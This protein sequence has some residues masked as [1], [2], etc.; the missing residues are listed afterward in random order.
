MSNHDDRYLAELREN[1]PQR[2][3]LSI[4]FGGFKGRK[5]RADWVIVE[6]EPGGQREWY[7]TTPRQQTMSRVEGPV[8]ALR[9]AG[10]HD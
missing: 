4:E 6:R 7:V 2:E 5:S 3:W 9:R 8:E 1:Y 10:V